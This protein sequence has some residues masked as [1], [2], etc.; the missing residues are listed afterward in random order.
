MRNLLTICHIAFARV[1]WNL[2]IN[3][4]KLNNCKQQILSNFNVAHKKNN[5]HYSSLTGIVVKTEIRMKR[6]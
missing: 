5:V 3:Q 6:Q 1:N 4:R 2:Q